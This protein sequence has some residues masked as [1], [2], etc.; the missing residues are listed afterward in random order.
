MNDPYIQ[1]LLD[2]IQ[3]LRALINKLVPDYPIPLSAEES[4][5]S[6]SGG[7]LD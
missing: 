6:L 2:E 1:S 7:E 5:S 3:F 4:D